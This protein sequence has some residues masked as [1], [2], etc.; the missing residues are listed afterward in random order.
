MIAE[1]KLA[2]GYSWFRKGLIASLLTCS[3]FSLSLFYRYGDDAGHD[4]RELLE[5]GNF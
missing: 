3:P 1:R 2:R 5:F 4:E